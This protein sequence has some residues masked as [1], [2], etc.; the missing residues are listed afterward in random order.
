MGLV[1]YIL[2]RLPSESLN[3]GVPWTAGDSLL[4]PSSP[5]RVRRRGS[6]RTGRGPGAGRA[7]LL[8]PRVR[9]V[10]HGTLG[11]AQPGFSGPTG[12]IVEKETPSLKGIQPPRITGS[13]KPILFP[14]IT[15][16][17]HHLCH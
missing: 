4:V 3:T 17:L 14:Q 10:L 15:L 12:N 1:E 9:H 11:N 5:V 2:L 13:A 6:P 8:N 7:Y 16:G